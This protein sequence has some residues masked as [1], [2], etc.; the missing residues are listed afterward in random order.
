MSKIYEIEVYT[1]SQNR[2]AGYQW[3][4]DENP[5]KIL[6]ESSTIEEAR[7]RLVMRMTVQ[8]W[9]KIGKAVEVS[10]DNRWLVLSEYR[11]LTTAAQV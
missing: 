4:T 11:A 7:E 6:I 2:H 10:E 1:M 5:T 3:E 9:A 8:R